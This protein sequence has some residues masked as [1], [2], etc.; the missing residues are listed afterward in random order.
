MLKN[1]RHANMPLTT[2]SQTGLNEAK[3]K[4]DKRELLKT[5]GHCYKNSGE[6]IAYSCNGLPEVLGYREW[7]NREAQSI[8]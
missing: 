5:E 7:A 2:A 8:L 1:R 6:V 3:K 4:E